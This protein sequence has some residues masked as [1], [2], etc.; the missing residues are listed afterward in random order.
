MAEIDMARFDRL[1][2]ALG[3]QGLSR[4][5]SS[6]VSVIFD[7]DAG[8]YFGLPFA[9]AGVP[10][11]LISSSALSPNELVI[12]VKPDNADNG[13]NASDN[14]SRNLR[15]HAYASAFGRFNLR[16]DLAVGIVGE[17]GYRNME[18]LLGG[19]N[20]I[21]D[22][23]SN[24]R[25]K[26]SALDFA[27]KH[28]SIYLSAAVIPGY[29]KLE[30]SCELS[31]QPTESILMDGLGELEKKFFEEIN[32]TAKDPDE[33]AALVRSAN[34]TK[35]LIAMFLGGIAADEIVRALIG[36]EEV[37]DQQLHFKFGYGSEMFDPLRFGERLKTLDILDMQDKA[38]LFFGVG[39]VGTNA[40]YALARAGIGRADALDNDRVD[41]TNVL[42][43]LFYHDRVNVEKAIAFAQ[44][45]PVIS[46]GRTAST[47]FYQKL[48]EGT[49]GLIL[50][51]RYDVYVDGFDTFGARRLAAT[52]AE[53]DETPIITA[54]GRYDGFD[55]EAYAPG[56]TLCV[57][58]NFRLGELA[59]KELAEA[60]KRQSCG[61]EYTPQNSWINQS[62]G[63]IVAATVA[64]TF[65][66]DKY[67]EPVN[68][69]IFYDPM[70]PARLFVNTKHGKC[71][72][73]EGKVGGL[74]HNM[75]GVTQDAK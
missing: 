36:K 22:C 28:G 40:G 1:F 72:K 39:G 32:G 29:G 38:A 50:P 14:A 55:V 2:R 73:S 35:E 30:L 23:T 25:S 21:I 65:R 13:T 64:S 10:V 47:G 71:A 7:S 45:I 15:A 56:R 16:N 42:R 70:L 66:P 37:L 26:Q 19:S 67:G 57:D 9:M 43:T 5:Q 74:L 75:D 34:A 48:S 20:I 6:V 4:L 8:K 41:L 54:S 52:R 60:S 69:M 17:L 27:L 58:C 49:D 3:E 51:R 11:R 61:A 33:H 31:S 59:A 62:V 68:G 24:P 18:T 63:A 44:K 53:Q 12:D 46:G